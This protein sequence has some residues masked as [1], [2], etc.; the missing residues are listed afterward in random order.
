MK[1]DILILCRK[2]F[3]TILHSLI[4]LLILFSISSCH[5]GRYFTW[6]F[7]DIRD[8]KK[9]PADTIK[10]G[11]Y[12][13]DF[14]N[15]EKNL[16]LMIPKD[17]TDKSKD[18]EDFL[19]RHKTLALII[20]KND[21]ILYEHYFSGYHREKIHPTFSIAK[22]FVSALTGIAIREGYIKNEGQ[23][24]TDFLKE[25]K[26]KEF[27]KVQI[28]NLLNMRSGIGFDES[29]KNPFGKIAKFYY[30]KNLK[31]YTYKLKV[32][33]EPGSEYKYQSANSQLLGYTIE[34]ATGKPLGKYLEEKLW[35]PI[36]M[37]YNAT[38]SYDSKKHKSI[39]AFCCLNAR[40]IDLAK[41]GRLFLIDG[42]WGS[43]QIIDKEWIKKSS[44]II[45][46]SKDS[47]GYNYSFGWRVCET[48]EFFAKGLLGQYIW[49]DPGK[50]LIIV[51]LGKSYSNIDWAD[52]FN[53]ISRQL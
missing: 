38:W 21:T 14:Y 22:V 8:Y 25:L 32:K 34:K 10:T 23:Y 27:S 4:L 11:H 2:N 33:K 5:V 12:S 31:K 46:D 18:F 16:S 53:N 37:E 48:G 40:A 9:F 7:A 47:Q 30:G 15:T 52:F 13:F 49:I 50:E 41:F 20:I 51:R 39:K 45:N 35:K 3:R 24:I 36:G 43:D 28:V 42:K 29:Y 1:A 6:N 26:D 19:E 44:S 17:F